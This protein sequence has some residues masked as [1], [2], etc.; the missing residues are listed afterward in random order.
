MATPA[1]PD[2][3]P[4]S[5]FDN[6][7]SNTRFGYKPS[8]TGTHDLPA[9]AGGTSVRTGDIEYSLLGSSEDRQLGIA[10]ETVH[11]FLTPKLN[12][13]RGLRGFVRAQG[14][15]RSYILRYLEEALAET[16]AQLRVRGV[17]RANIIKGAHFPVKYGY[18]S[19]AQMG[20]E[21]RGLLLGP[22]NVGGSVYNVWYSK[23]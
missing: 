13:L 15:N 8:I 22:I 17:S 16:Y 7:P 5:S 20:Q 11:Q 21:A 4:R 18:V 12:L 3:L 10:H 1:R 23:Q 14:Y 2:P 19:F 9:G 6:L